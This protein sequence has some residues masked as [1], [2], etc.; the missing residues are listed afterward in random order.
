MTIFFSYLLFKIHVICMTTF[1]LIRNRIWLYVLVC[2]LVYIHV[3]YITFVVF[4]SLTG[5]RWLYFYSFSINFSLSNYLLNICCLVPVSS[6][7]K[8]FFFNFIFIA[9][10]LNFK[11][12]YFEYYTSYNCIAFNFVQI[13]CSSNITT[14][15]LICSQKNILSFQWKCTCTTSS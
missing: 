15:L 12:F 8:T 14:C 2:F 10:K 4:H 7:Y 3:T 9:Q 11:I 6:F 13:N 5:Y 1:K